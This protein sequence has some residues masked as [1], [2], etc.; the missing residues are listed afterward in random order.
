[1]MRRPSKRG[2]RNVSFGFSGVLRRS[3][4]VPGAI[5][6]DRNWPAAL[7]PA[8]QS[9]WSKQRSGTKEEEPFSAYNVYI[10]S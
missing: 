1:M 3:R 2:N 4:T 6:I 10:L 9:S 8:L 7:C 5:E